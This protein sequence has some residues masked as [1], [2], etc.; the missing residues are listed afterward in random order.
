MVRR[1]LLWHRQDWKIETI[2]ELLSPTDWPLGYLKLF[3]RSEEAQNAFWTQAKCP[4]VQG[5]PILRYCTS[6]FSCIRYLFIQI[7]YTFMCMIWIEPKR[8]SMQDADI[9][10][11][12]SKNFHW[13]LLK[14]VQFTPEQFPWDIKVTQHLNSTWLQFNTESTRQCLYLKVYIRMRLQNM[15]AN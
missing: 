3:S 13:E 9:G 6:P 2:K 14:N 4:H 8:A 5:F 10:N 15:T 11:T 1:K 12:C 7:I